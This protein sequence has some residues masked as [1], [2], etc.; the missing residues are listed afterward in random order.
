MIRSDD[1]NN[2]ATPSREQLAKLAIKNFLE[3][4]SPAV[5]LANYRLITGSQTRGRASG[6]ETAGMERLRKELMSKR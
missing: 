4:M 6:V 1:I 3:T 2:Y 5:R